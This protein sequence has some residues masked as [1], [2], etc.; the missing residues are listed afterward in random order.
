MSA[1]HAHKTYIQDFDHLIKKRRQ[2][3]YARHT[4][5]ISK[6]IV[7]QDIHTRHTKIDINKRTEKVKSCIARHTNKTDPFFLICLANGFMCLVCMSCRAG[8]LRCTQVSCDAPRF[9]DVVPI[10]MYLYPFVPYISMY[11]VCFNEK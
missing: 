3:M 6:Y 11:N 10:F 8:V 4:Y 1:R 2:D 9:T 7:S 5:K